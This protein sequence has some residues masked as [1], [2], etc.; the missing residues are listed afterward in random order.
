[1]QDTTAVT[2]PGAPYPIRVEVPYPEDLNRFLPLI[3]WLLAIPH[4][5]VL[6]FLNIAFSIVSFIAF[7]AILF[8]TKYPDGL[9]KFAVGYRRWLLNVNAYALLLRD[10]YPPFSIEPGEYPAS[11]EVDYPEDLNRWLPLVKWLLAIPHYLVLLVL[12]IAWFILTLVVVF[13]ILF[14]AKYPRTWFDFSV[15]VMRWSE[16]VNDYVYLM[17]DVYPP[18]SLKP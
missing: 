2:T 12:G 1:M 14:T 8:T 11:L 17:T 9:F 18:F 4:Y 10:E 5:I 3:K 6:Y 7:F 13:V 15:G 16:R